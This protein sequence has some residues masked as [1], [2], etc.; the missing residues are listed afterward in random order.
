MAADG[1]L[2]SGCEALID[3]HNGEA[4]IE[5]VCTH[6]SFRKRGFARAVIMEC[7]FRLQGMGLRRAY[8]TGYSTVAVALYASLG[9][10]E[11]STSYIY[12]TAVP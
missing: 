7:L 10:G 11:E 3:A 2:V 12:E 5:R 9:R 1:R 8:I 4:D 6:S